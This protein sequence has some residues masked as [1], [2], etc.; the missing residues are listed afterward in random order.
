[1]LPAEMLVKVETPSRLSRPLV[2]SNSCCVVMPK[3]GGKVVA[4]NCGDV[5]VPITAVKRV[6][7]RAI[8]CELAAPGAVPDGAVNVDT[9]N[10][11]VW[12]GKMSATL[13][14]F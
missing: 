6:K 9:G 11:T 1:M 7:R 10:A 14:E 8:L 4:L 5:G 2:V 13:V 12:P 3:N